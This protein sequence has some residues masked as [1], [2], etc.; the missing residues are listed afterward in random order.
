MSIPA[1]LTE[2]Y[3]YVYSL[4]NKSFKIFVQGHL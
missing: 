4:E 1:E 3:L 2:E